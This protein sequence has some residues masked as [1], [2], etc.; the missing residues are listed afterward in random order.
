MIVVVI[1]P[2][3]TTVVVNLWILVHVRSSSRRVQPISTISSTIPG[4][5][6][7]PRI[8]S[9]DI[10]LLR[11]VVIMLVLFMGGMIPINLLGMIQI[12]TGQSYPLLYASLVIWME[13]CLLGD[14]INL[15]IYNRELRLYLRRLIKPEMI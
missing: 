9:R 10:I 14:M 4:Q 1:V 8:R 6:Q 5:I 3:I 12:Y 7:R 11:H 13:L 2:S 15:F